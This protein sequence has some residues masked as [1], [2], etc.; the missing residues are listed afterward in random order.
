MKNKT[1][2]EKF[3]KTIYLQEG[4]G[5]DGETTWC[6]DK[7]HEDDIEYIRKDVHEKLIQE[8]EDRGYEAGAQA[9]SDD[10]TRVIR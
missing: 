6:P 2:T 10:I 4:E 8:A 9:A 1:K 5:F 3:P 7:I